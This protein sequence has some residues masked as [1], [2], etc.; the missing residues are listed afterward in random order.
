MKWSLLILILLTSSTTFAKSYISAKIIS[1][2]TVY[3]VGEPIYI[4]TKILNDTD[5]VIFYNSYAPAKYLKISDQNNKQLKL[6]IKSSSESEIHIFP[7]D[8]IIYFSEITMLFGRIKVTN[9]K[10]HHGFPTGEYIVKFLMEQEDVHI[11]S[12]TLRITVIEPIPEE[13]EAFKLYTEA[14][15]NSF[16][17]KNARLGIEESKNIFILLVEKY[18]ESVYAPSAI[19]FAR[20]RDFSNQHFY[21][22]R[23]I[24]EYP[25]SIESWFAINSIISDYQSNKDKIGAENYLRSII[26]DFPG[27]FAAKDARKRLEEILQLSLEEWLNPRLVTKRKLRKYQIEQRKR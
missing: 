27:T 18:P 6:N 17:Q 19:R 20:N 23:M 4:K 15:I 16:N 25:N 11:E 21:N 14:W 2:K 9:E 13:V 24:K 10:N 26:A 7:A 3:L 22:E 12:N 1:Q 8:S 5:E